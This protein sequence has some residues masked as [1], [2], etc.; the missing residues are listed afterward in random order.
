MNA[1]R[2]LGEFII[3]NQSTFAFSTG[4]LSK[5]L[6]GIRLAAKM[7][8]HEVNKASGGWSFPKPDNKEAIDSLPKYQLYNLN[9]DP[10]EIFN[11]YQKNAGKAEELKTLLIKSIVEAL[12]T[13]GEPQK[14][15]SINFE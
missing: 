7:V 9:S 5:L 13:S 14:N 2:T 11:L 15:D 1:N 8:N 3:E 12:R 10:G 6:N 4:E